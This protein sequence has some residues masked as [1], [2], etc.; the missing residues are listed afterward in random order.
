MY[1]PETKRRDDEETADNWFDLAETVGLG[2]MNG[3]SRDG[4]GQEYVEERTIKTDGNGRRLPD[5]SMGQ[6]GPNW[7]DYP[8]G[9]V[10]TS[11]TRADGS[12]TGR[13]QR[14][15]D[16]IAQTLEDE[17]LIQTIPKFR[18]GD[19]PKE[20]AKIAR[21]ACERVVGGLEKHMLDAN[22]AR[23]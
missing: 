4:R 17:E 5:Y 8:S 19:D 7:A 10:N 18:E 11:S 2:R 15:R 9:H 12:L 22:R 16:A 6:P 3:A 20:Y 14:A 23:N 13:E 1:A 21:A